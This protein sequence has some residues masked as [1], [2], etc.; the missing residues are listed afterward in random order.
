M[1]KMQRLQDSQLPT[2]DELIFP[3]PKSRREKQQQERAEGI[4]NFE[5]SSM[6]TTLLWVFNGLGLALIGIA[7]AYI[8]SLFVM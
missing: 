2:F 1:P 6:V 3:Q 4:S 5:Y 7:A 8:T